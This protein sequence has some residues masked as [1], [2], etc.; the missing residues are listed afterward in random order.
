VS[1]DAAVPGVTE[2]GIRKGA[3]GAGCYRGRDARKD[4]KRPV[5]GGPAPRAGVSRE[6]RAPER[7]AA[8]V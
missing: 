3:T 4:S 5:A 1:I 6:I 8:T 2:E 7:V